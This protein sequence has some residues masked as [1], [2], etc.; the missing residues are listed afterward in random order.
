MN[1]LFARVHEQEATCAVGILRLTG[2]ETG[3]TEQ[4]GRLV[5]DCTADGNALKLLNTDNSRSNRAVNLARL[6]RLGKHTHRYAEL[7][8]KELIPLKLINIKEHCS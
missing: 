5:A 2:I 6:N 8:A 7:F 4:C 3:L 1:S